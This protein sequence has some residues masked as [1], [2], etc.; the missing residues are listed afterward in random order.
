MSKLSLSLAA[1]VV[2]AAFSP[3][4]LAQ[5]DAAQRFELISSDEQPLRDSVLGT[6]P[7]TVV[8]KMAGDS[9][10]VVR[11]RA[12]GKHMSESERRSVA[13]GLRQQQDAIAPS[14]EA[15]GGTVLAKMQHAINGIKV[16]ATPA[17]LASMAML[18][19]VVG[20]KPVL[21]YKPVN[22]VSV[23]FIGAPAVWGGSP[24]FRGEGIKIAIIDTGADFT[25]ANFGGP[26]TVAAFNTAFAHSTQPANP[27]LFGPNAPKIKGGTDLVGDDYN[28]SD[29]A[30]NTPHPSKT[31]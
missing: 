15:M 31:R 14:I 28:A 22:A 6:E 5:T 3:V 26:G 27:A 30:H 2:S 8:L 17:Q 19:G 9:V 21:T 4:S 23:P 25:H 20:I 24:A 18:P 16:R 10:A 1:A 11:S 13:D 29:P 12:A 7:L